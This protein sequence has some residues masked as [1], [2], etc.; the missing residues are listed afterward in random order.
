M[1]G[2]IKIYS[3]RHNSIAVIDERSPLNT[4]SKMNWTDIRIYLANNTI[5]CCLSIWLVHF[6]KTSPMFVE[7][8][9]ELMCTTPVNLAGKLLTDLH[10]DEMHCGGDI[11]SQSWWTTGRIMA[12]VGACVG[13]TVVSI[14]IFYVLIRR[15]PSR[16]G[17]TRIDD[18]YVHIDTG[19]PGGPV[20]PTPDDDD[21]EQYTSYSHI[22]DTRH[23]VP[24][25]APTYSTG[26]GTYAADTSHVGYS[27]ID[28]AAAIPRLV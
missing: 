28:D 14:A 3:F 10:P 19:L 13:V 27:A 23:T 8:K 15:R 16:S 5:D 2:R 11:P 18:P 9:L 25:E 22:D 6:L 1:P 20:F 21:D 4:W 12:V 24:S 26:D 7:D 17:Y